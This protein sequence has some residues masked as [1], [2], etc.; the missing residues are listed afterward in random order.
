MSKDLTLRDYYKII[1]SRKWFIVLFTFVFTLVAMGISF[2][3]PQWYAGYAQV[4]RPQ[5]Q[6]LDAT[7][8]QFGG[9]MSI[10]GGGDAAT[11]RYVAILNSYALKKQVVD[12]FDLIRSYDVKGMDKAVKE[13]S[14][15]Y[16]IQ[17][18]DE[19][20]IIITIFDKD[21]ER[22]ASMVNYILGVSD[23]IN[24]TLARAY[25]KEE[26][27]FIENQ[28]N[29]ILD[30]LTTLEMRLSAYMN[31][32][33]V[34]SIDEQLKSEIEFASQLKYQIMIKETELKIM[35]QTRESEMVVESNRI[36]LED[37]KA[38]YAKLFNT[39]ND[40]FLDLS[41][42]Q[43]IGIFMQKVERELEYYNQLLLYI[44]PLY[45]QAKISEAKYIPSFEVLDYAHRPDRKAKPKKA[46]IVI[47]AFMFAMLSSGIYVLLKENKD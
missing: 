32:H 42:A 37:L 12:K 9:A 38:Q 22:V 31:K 15:N 46:V 2:L 17:T 21:Q 34:L 24:I 20:Q 44:A 8:Y 16:K 1:M 13:L 41:N 7:G 18:G 27:I 28:L 23:S 30:S 26:R 14:E 19:G 47:S 10:L 35:E 5:S 6:V 36:T 25:G 39:G 4:I 3:L 45:E 29:G 33:N 43:D 40:L 11:N